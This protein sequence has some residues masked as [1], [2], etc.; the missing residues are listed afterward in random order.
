MNAVN[1]RP[2]FTKGGDQNG[3]LGAAAKSVP[4]WATAISTGAADEAAQK[5]SF[6][7]T[8]DHP[9]LFDTQPAI[10]A[11]GTLSYKPSLTNTGSA[12][13]T[14][15][16]HDDGGTSNGGVDLSY[17]QTFNLHIGSLM[18][19]LGIYNGLVGAPAGDPAEHA[20]SGVV[21]VVMS[22]TGTFTGKLLLGGKTFSIKG[23]FDGDG[24]AHFGPTKLSSLPLLRTG[25]PPLALTLQ[26]DAAGST[27][28]LTGK[29]TEGGVAFAS[30]AADRALYTA[31]LSPVAPLRMCQPHCSA[32]T[33]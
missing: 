17:P 4:N 18:E 14:V 23:M 13:V 7:V 11:A 27:G 15:V 30:I 9:E 25:L 22:K 12:L 19:E 10:S 31:K 33:P 29:I 16:L 1:S 32:D 20:K 8:T 3:A 21:R 5:L 2:R 28:T 6:T 26:V 24:A